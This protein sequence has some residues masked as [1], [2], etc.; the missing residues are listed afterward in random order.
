MSVPQSPSPPVE[1]IVITSPTTVSLTKKNPT[2][3][4]TAIANPPKATN[5]TWISNNIKIATVDENGLIKAVASGTVYISVVTGTCGIKPTPPIVVTV[6]MSSH[7]LSKDALY[8]IVSSGVLLIIIVVLIILYKK[9]KCEPA[10][11]LPKAKSANT[12]V[13]K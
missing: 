1:S 5:W 13:I 7:T 12:K 6:D 10:S 8:G 3:Q 11:I 2:A 9:K 4:A